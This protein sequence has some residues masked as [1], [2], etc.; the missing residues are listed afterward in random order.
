MKD[1]GDV[2]AI[3]GA[4]ISTRAFGEATQM[5]YDVFVETNPSKN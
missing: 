1:G 2:D 3:A 5:A 4:T